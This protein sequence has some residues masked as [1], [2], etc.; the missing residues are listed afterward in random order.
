VGFSLIF[1][2]AIYQKSRQ[3]VFELLSAFAFGLILEITNIFFSQAYNYSDQF[4]FRIFDVPIVVGMGWAIIIYSAMLLSDQYRI[5]WKIKPFF[6]AFTVLILDIS[7]DVVAIRLGFWNWQIP[8]DQEWFGVPFENLFGWMAVAFTFSF[9]IRFIRTLNPKRF[10]F[11]YF[12][13]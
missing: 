11:S 4:L 6:D 5:P 8:F 9:V 12:L 1:A 13:N 10:L 3:T 7:M 2:R